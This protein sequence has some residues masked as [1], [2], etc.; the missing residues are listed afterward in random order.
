MKKQNLVFSFLDNNETFEFENGFSFI[1]NE[2]L[3]NSL[4][5]ENYKIDD[6][7]LIV[8]SFDNTKA[9]EF[10]QLKINI[11]YIG[12]FLVNFPFEENAKEKYLPL[13]DEIKSLKDDAEEKDKQLLKI[14]KVILI[15]NKYKPI[16]SIFI[17]RED[18]FLYLK[19]CNKVEPTFPLLFPQIEEE[20]TVK[21]VE[22]PVKEKKESKFC[23]KDLFK[24]NLKDKFKFS[25]K[26]NIEPPFFSLDFLFHLLFSLFLSFCLYVSIALFYQEDLKGLFFI[27]Q[28]IFYGFCL[29]YNLYSCKYK[30]KRKN[31]KGE[32][33][34]IY[35][36]IFL[37]TSLGCLLSVVFSTYV[38]KLEGVPF[39]LAPTLI[40]FVLC[41]GILP[42]IKLVKN[43]IE[44]RKH[45]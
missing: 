11:K 31:Q 8:K 21:V 17:G 25:L 13:I 40:S 37:G 3:F 20:V 39:L 28:F 35:S 42:S 29:G 36:Y 33:I 23:F 9:N 30:G 43:L 44:K 2:R 24:F 38:L 5:C 4:K 18:T 26:I 41:L 12:Y 15:L 14:E 34:I 10:F 27:V 6:S 19:E 16:Y 45:Y 7:L 32:D 1:H 22:K